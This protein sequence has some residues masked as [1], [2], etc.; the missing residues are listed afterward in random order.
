[1][2]RLLAATLGVLAVLTAAPVFAS[3]TVSYYYNDAQGSPVA[4]TDALAAGR[5]CALKT[6]FLDLQRKLSVLLRRQT[7]RGALLDA[8]LRDIG[9]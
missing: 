7:Y 6:P 4:V 1:M 3:D 9:V 8:F 2:K 5:L